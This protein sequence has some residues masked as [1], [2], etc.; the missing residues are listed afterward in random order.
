MFKILILKEFKNILLSPKFVATFAIASLLIIL[1]IFIGINEYKTAVEQY[2]AGLQLAEQQIREARSWAGAG[3]TVF[4]KPNPMQVF[5]SGVN[6]DIGR[7]SEIGPHSLIKLR[8]S[9]Y[10]DDPIFAIFRSIDFV[11]IVQIVLSLLAILFTFDAINGEKE[12]GTL[13]LVLCNAIPRSQ[14]LI[15][16]VVGS[17]MG[18]VIPLSVPLLLGILI[19]LLSGI[20]MEGVWFK[21]FLLVALSLLYFTFFICFGILISA[22]TQQSSTSFL[23]LLVSWV[24]WVLVIPRIGIM[25]AGQLIETR[26]QAELESQIEQFENEQWSKHED[27]LINKNKERNKI[28]EG[29]STED[30][31]AYREEHM[32]EWMEEDDANRSAMQQEIIEYKRRAWEEMINKKHLQENLG[33]N[34]A[35]I[36]PASVYLIAAMNVA[37]TDIHIKSRTEQKIDDY[38]RVFSA[39]TQKKQDESG[40]Q[41]GGIQVTMDS[42]VGM[43]IKVSDMKKTVDISEMPKFVDKPREL[44]NVLANTIVDTGILS[45]MIILTFAA[46]FIA[47][48][49][50]DVR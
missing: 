19:V 12:S 23:V 5:V 36:S 29:M 37:D 14:Y 3:T 21:L 35:R 2:E 33:L 48:I 20:P 27:Y 6:N 49:R 7:L 24:L 46:S 45:V 50:Y 9:M 1:S 32:W 4:R 8:N 34:L 30:R 47:F 39:F 22:L 13:K 40:V 41:G 31:V 26:G 16:K 42:D 18:L 25:T 43:S 10:S 11:F 15:S 17:W 28:T 38:S 44:S